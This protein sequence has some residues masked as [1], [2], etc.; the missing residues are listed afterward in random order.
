LS[1]SECL[2]NG[3]ETVYAFES[4]QSRSPKHVLFLAGTT[5]WKSEL[6][7]ESWRRYFIQ[8]LEQETTISDTVICI[9]EPRSGSFGEE[10]AKQLIEWETEHLDKAN[11]HAYWHRACQHHLSLHCCG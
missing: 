8:Q 2:S 5:H 1:Q 7:A 11:L 10:G 4:I 3:I 6:V 9:P